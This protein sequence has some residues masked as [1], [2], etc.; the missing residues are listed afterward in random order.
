MATFKSFKCSVSGHQHESVLHTSGTELSEITASV[1][2]HWDMTG[3]AAQSIFL[4]VLAVM[5][6][7][8]V[9]Q[10]FRERAVSRSASV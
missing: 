9:Q 10:Q 7:H 6:P 5:A 3:I 2:S 8:P 4:H 1:V